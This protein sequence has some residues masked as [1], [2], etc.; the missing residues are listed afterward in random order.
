MG[1]WSQR[2]RF[3][4]HLIG[5]KPHHPLLLGKKSI[6]TTPR[7]WE[8]GKR[9]IQFL[10]NEAT[11]GHSNPIMEQNS[12]RRKQG[13]ALITFFSLSGSSESETE[14]RIGFWASGQR[15]QSASLALDRSPLLSV[16]R[17]TVVSA[18]GIGGISGIGVVFQMAEA[19]TEQVRR[20]SC[21]LFL[22]PLRSRTSERGV[23]SSWQGINAAFTWGGNWR[24]RKRNKLDE[25]PKK[26]KCLNL[27]AFP[28]SA[29][30]PAVEKE[31]PAA[32]ALKW[33]KKKVAVGEHGALGGASG[34]RK[35][36]CLRGEEDN[37]R[38]H[39]HGRAL[40][41]V[42]VHGGACCPP[43]PI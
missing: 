21:L 14:W 6:P 4:A 25:L 26:Q 36:A 11:I 27:L 7:W 38:R 1:F 16:P 5:I 28:T 18:S 30:R 39:R 41:V 29:H 31:Q 32:S 37:A 15:M 22:G 40:V 8:K 17:P 3:V 35:S 10:S 12:F 34:A 9:K 43:L 19:G 24:E 2:A 33:K 13:K 42:S 20:E 23:T